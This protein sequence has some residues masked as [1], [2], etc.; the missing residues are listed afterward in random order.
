MEILH[1]YDC[2]KAVPFI[3][4]VTGMDVDEYHLIIS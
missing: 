3:M 1:W 2:G 4:M